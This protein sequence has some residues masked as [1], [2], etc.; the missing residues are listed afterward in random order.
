EKKD[1]LAATTVLVHPARWEPFGISVI[2]GMAAGKPAVVADATGPALTVADGETGFVVP[3]G[4]AKALAHALRTLL[5]DPERAAAM[6]AAGARRVQE[7]Y[8]AR[9][10]AERLGDAIDAVSTFI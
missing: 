5:R 10:A 7:R 9:V 4:D 8:H 6:G 3:K 2:E 1:V